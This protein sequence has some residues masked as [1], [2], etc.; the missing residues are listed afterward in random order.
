MPASQTPIWAHQKNKMEKLEN[1]SE[2]Q[3]GHSG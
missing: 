1:S 2:I 3:I